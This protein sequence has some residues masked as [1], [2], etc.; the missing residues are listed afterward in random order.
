MNS[1]R[2]WPATKTRREST[3]QLSIT[4]NSS[5]WRRPSFNYSWI[6]GNAIWPTA[7]LK[8][9]WLHGEVRQGCIAGPI[10]LN[11]FYTAMLSEATRDLQCGVFTRFRTTRKLFN[12]SRLRASTKVFEQILHELLYADD[13][14]LEAHSLQAGL[15]ITFERCV[16]VLR[17]CCSTKWK[18]RSNSPI[19]WSSFL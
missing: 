15:K 11:L 10:L 19:L 16:A 5:L 7:A 2:L 14:A 3:A 6:S 18:L 1:C 13:C 12:L 8:E 17:V 4:R 9:V